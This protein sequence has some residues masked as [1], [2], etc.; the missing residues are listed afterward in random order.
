M[1]EKME[2][3]RKSER[4]LIDQVKATKK[5]NFETFEITWTRA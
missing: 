5:D 2:Q 1:E 4:V 3:G